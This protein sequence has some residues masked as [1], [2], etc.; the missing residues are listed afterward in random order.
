[1]MTTSPRRSKFRFRAFLVSCASILVLSAC[2]RATPVTN[3]GP[4]SDPRPESLT[5]ISPN[6]FTPFFQEWFES[7]GATDVE[8]RGA[9]V[10]RKGNRA[11]F[12]ARGFT[13]TSTDE[14]VEFLTTLPDGRIIQD[15][16]AGSATETSAAHEEVL[17]NFSVTTMHVINAAFFDDHDEMQLVRNVTI[18]SKPR[19][20][21]VG[22]ILSMGGA[23]QPDDASA[24]RESVVG[25]ITST[26]PKDDLPH[27]YKVVYG[28]SDGK[29]IA[30]EASMDSTS[31]SD[32]SRKMANVSWPKSGSGFYTFKLFVLVK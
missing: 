18:N 31:E 29:P 3:S 20:I 22:D 27:W 14:E 12:A 17:H 30:L 26:S 1:M 15:F 11:S 10:S 8:T 5:D 28:E 19:K 6:E 21:Y 25:A 7:V 2:G 13:Q 24:L 4:N 16:V 9:A 23:L 32:F